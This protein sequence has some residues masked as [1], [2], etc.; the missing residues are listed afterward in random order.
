MDKPKLLPYNDSLDVDD[1]MDMEEWI[2]GTIFE[3]TDA[4]EEGAKELSVEILNVILRKFLPGVVE[5][6]CKHCGEQLFM[7][8]KGSRKG[9]WLHHEWDEDPAKEEYGLR[10][11]RGPAATAATPPDEYLAA[12]KG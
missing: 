2:A 8:T 9:H 5:P 12:L 3:A 10:G 7:A 4:T 1:Q 6:M 11:C